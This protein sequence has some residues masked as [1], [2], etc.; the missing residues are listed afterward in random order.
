M[1]VITGLAKGKK[2]KAPPGKDTR[3]ITDM[4]KGALFNV[5]GDRILDAQFLDLFAG[6]GSVGIEAISRGAKQATFVELSRTAVT[7]IRENLNNCKFSEKALIYETD[8]LKA[9]EI[10]SRQNKTFD[11]VYI[12]PPFTNEAIFSLVMIKMGEADIL[13]Q[14]GMLIIR[15]KNGKELAE[16]FKNL[17]QYRYNKYGD[18]CLRYYH[19]S[20]EE[21]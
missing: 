13:K 6:S 10:L 21:K 2:I 14:N 8:V 4:I 11:I 17:I 20:G 3:P 12:D 19:M 9:I 5:I 16:K 7:I 18:S 1:R 15:T